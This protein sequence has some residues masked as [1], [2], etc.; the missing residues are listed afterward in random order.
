MRS[1]SLIAAVFIGLMSCGCSSQ[2][3]APVKGRVMFNGKPVKAAAVTF[4]P[5]GA[6]GQKETGK[7]GTGFT[8]DDGNFQLST[9][10]NYDGA[11]VGNHAVLVTLDDTNPAKCKREK[12]LT[13]E[14][15]SGPNEFTIEMDPK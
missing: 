14:V 8:D 13:L 3:M 12:S 7:P 2:P 4:S 10:S 6:A 5:A 11:L 1:L 15:K 9:F